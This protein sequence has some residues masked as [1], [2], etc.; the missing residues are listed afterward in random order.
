MNRRDFLKTVVASGL[1]SYVPL[2]RDEFTISDNITKNGPLP[3]R[4]LGKTGESLS[5]IGLGGVVFRKMEDT[6][7]A[8]KIVTDAVEAGVNFVD[9]APAYGNAQEILGPIIKPFRRDL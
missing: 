3:R 7:R 9:V 2:S 8:N 4:P 6:S 5:I 1:A